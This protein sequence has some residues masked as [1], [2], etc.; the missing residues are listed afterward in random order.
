MPVYCTRPRQPD[1]IPHDT[2]VPTEAITLGLKS[3]VCAV[4]GMPICLGNGRYLPIAEL[5]QGGFGRTFLAEDLKFERTKRVIKQFRTDRLLLSGQLAQALTAFE[6]E[7]RILDRLKHNQIPR[8]YEPFEVTAPADR[9]LSSMISAQTYYY[10]VQEYIPGEDLQQMIG[11]GERFDEA[12]VRDLLVQLLGILD[13]IHTLPKPVIHRDIKPSNILRRADGTYHL[14]DFGAVK[15]MM[16]VVEAESGLSPLPTNFATPG[17]SP[18][19]QGHEEIDVSADLYALA[20]T[21]ICLLTGQPGAVGPWQYGQTVSPSLGRLLNQMI[22]VNPGDRPRSAKAV[23]QCLSLRSRLGSFP[24]HQVHLKPWLRVYGFWLL[25]LVGLPI[26]FCLLWF[27]FPL[28][29]SSAKLPVPALECQESV[30]SEDAIPT[31]LPAQPEQIVAVQGVPSLLNSPPARYGGSTTWI[32]LADSFNTIARDRFRYFQLQRVAPP[33]GQRWHSEEGVRRLINGELDFALSSKPLI[34]EL[35]CAAQQRG[36]RLKRFLVARSATAVVVN[37]SLKI[38]GMTIEQF[39]KIKRGEIR[40]WQMLGGPDREITIYMT[41]ESYLEGAPFIKVKNATDSLKQ[42]IK[43]EFGMTI[44]PGNV[45]VRQCLV[46]ALPIGKQPGE[47]ISPYQQPERSPDDCL[48]GQKNVINP[49]VI[50]NSSYPLTAELTVVVQADPKKSQA[51]EAYA[52]MLLTKEG[53]QMV[54]GFGYAA[55]I[56]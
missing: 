49:Q 10:F 23:Q 30:Q 3:P 37:P 32:P 25:G 4:C 21:C 24:P 13:Y 55:V 2:Q 34:K 29:S 9:R 53:Q 19:E 31:Q 45:A 41:D 48:A 36:I 27:K 26:G 35:R 51:G 11:R 42:V 6:R 18:P 46:R 52:K 33:S 1:E 39:G 12:A 16:A 5:G 54:E 14:V 17:F 47:F 20:K 8:V 7:A 15:Q 44:A 50:D 43:N 38:P 56:K 40:N 22:A 28:G